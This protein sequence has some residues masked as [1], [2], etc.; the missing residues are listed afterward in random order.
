MEI[1]GKTIVV[2][3]TKRFLQRYT[4]REE[5][6]PY[7]IRVVAGILSNYECD[8]IFFRRDYDTQREMKAEIFINPEKGY[9]EVR[10][11][12]NWNTENNPSF[13]VV[14]KEDEILFRLWHDSEKSEMNEQE[15][16][17]Q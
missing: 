1:N 4:N 15:V 17:V 10:R 16:F 14:I 12:H 7:F 6:F 2:K 3:A 8:E 9:E 11:Y 5:H 13:R